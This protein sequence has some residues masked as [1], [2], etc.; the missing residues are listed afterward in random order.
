MNNYISDIP[1]VKLQ[2]LVFPD[3]EKHNYKLF[4]R[5]NFN[6]LI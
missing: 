4:N 6:K 2:F 3:F 5:S 1:M